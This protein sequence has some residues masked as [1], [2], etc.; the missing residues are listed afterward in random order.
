MEKNTQKQVNETQQAL[1]VSAKV[2]AKL[3]GVSIRQVWRLNSA[4][5][6]PK[7]IRLGGSVRWRRD[8]ILAFIE[9]G[10]PDRETWERIKVQGGAA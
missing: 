1:V 4:G 6:L 2:L 8:E 7:P 10:A 3:L 5:K 9:A